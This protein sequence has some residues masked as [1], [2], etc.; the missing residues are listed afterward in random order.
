MM[1]SLPKMISMI[2]WAFYHSTLTLVRISK[3][4]SSDLSINKTIGQLLLNIPIDLE[5]S[6]RQKL[7]QGKNL[8]SNKFMA[9]LKRINKVQPLK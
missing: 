9:I 5:N 4:Q 8:I 7:N 6:K 2:V 3:N 1:E